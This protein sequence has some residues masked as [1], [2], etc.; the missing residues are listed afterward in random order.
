MIRGWIESAITFTLTNTCVILEKR[1]STA[2]TVFKLL[3]FV[4]RWIEACTKIR[5]GSIDT[6]EEELRNGIILAKLANTFHPASVKKIFE[7]R[8]I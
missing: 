2:V 4:L 3:N 5:I 1:K 8:E 6:L 7:V